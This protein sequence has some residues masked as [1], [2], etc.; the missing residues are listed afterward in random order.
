MPATS[1]T[2]EDTAAAKTVLEILRG[3]LEVLTAHI[4]DLHNALDGPPGAAADLA[5]KLRDR[6]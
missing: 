3:E 4:I 6:Y 5:R 1:T 2:T